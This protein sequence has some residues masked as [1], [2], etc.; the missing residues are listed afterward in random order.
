[1]TVTSELQSFQEWIHS[2]KL[3]INYHP[4]KSSY[5]VFK[6]GNKQL[7]SSYKSSL[8]VGGQEIK[9]KENTK[10]LGMILDDQLTWEKHITEVNTKI[11][12]YTDIFSKVRHLITEEC[13]LILYNSFVF[14][15]QN[16]GI[17]VY[18]N[19]EAK[20]LNASRYPKIKPLEFFILDIKGHQQM[21]ST[22]ILKS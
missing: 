1:M 13:R 10:Y 18:A 16:C 14:S 22:Q 20:F 6:P 17:E 12:K 7:L 3:T 8:H 11:V 4:Q 21:T 2:N 15:R 5:S 19:T 9:Y